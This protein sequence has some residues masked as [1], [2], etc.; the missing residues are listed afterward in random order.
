M[1]INRLTFMKI[2]KDFFKVIKYLL[3]GLW[4]IPIVLISR[5]IYPRFKIRFGVSQ[6]NRIGHFIPDTLEELIRM[7]VD[8]KRITFWSATLISNK[9]WYKMV[10][11][12]M[13]I[14]PIYK[15]LVFWNRYVPGSRRHTSVMSTNSSRDPEG[16][17]FSDLIKPN[18]SD[19]DNMKS[20]KLLEQIG[21]KG[22]QF[23][24]LLSRDNAYLNYL[25]KIAGQLNFDRSYHSYRNSDIETYRLAV[26]YLLDK[27]YWVFRMGTVTEKKLEIYH[28]NFLDY[29]YYNKKC[30][31]LDIYLFSNC[32]GLISTCTGIDGLSQAYGI[33]TLIVNGLPLGIATT[34]FNTIWVPKKLVWKNDSESLTLKEYVENF[35]NR[36]CEYEKAGIDIVDLNE[37]E[38]YNAVVELDARIQGN[39]HIDEQER[40]LQN[41][42]L[43]LLRNWNEFHLQHGFFHPGF[44]LGKDWIFSMR[45]KIS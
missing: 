9:Q 13:H 18:M 14:S 5:V 25:D 6:S 12:Y 8:K 22:E 24:C 19:S 1:E 41:S 37:I 21:W 31:L 15:Y 23:I 4:A 28:K 35:Y 29:P 34:Y 42:F 38:I 20:K 26:N 27:G 7:Q 44:K 39:H 45:N 3:N 33:P 43:D 10:K 40:K 30:D 11:K 16:K 2:I 36:T 17:F 32:S